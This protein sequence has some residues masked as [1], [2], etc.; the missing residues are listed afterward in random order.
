MNTRSMQPTSSSPITLKIFQ[1][2]EEY[3]KLGSSPVEWS[4]GQF[5]GSAVETY[6]GPGGF[7][8]FGQ[9]D[10]QVLVRTWNYLHA[11]HFT[12]ATRR[13]GAGIRGRFD[14]RN[15]TRYKRGNESAANLVPTQELNVG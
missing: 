12:H 13:I 10:S 1:S 9:N 14:G 5:T 3:L 6:F 4:G 2:K 7:D 8:G 15:V 11:N